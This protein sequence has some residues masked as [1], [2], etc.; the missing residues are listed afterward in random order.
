MSRSSADFPL[1]VD[2]GCVG[3]F[4][5]GR[6]VDFDNLPGVTR[7]DQMVRCRVADGS[8]VTLPLVEH[9]LLGKIATS[10]SAPISLL[11]YH[12]YA[13]THG[14]LSIHYSERRS[15]FRHR[16]MLH[17]FDAPLIPGVGYVTTYRT[18]CVAFEMMRL[19]PQRN[20]P[21]TTVP[22]S[23]A[24]Y[25]MLDFDR[26]G[27]PPPNITMDTSVPMDPPSTSI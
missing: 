25:I 5:L 22:P 17:L 27:A 10:Q 4:H 20:L 16:D 21:R 24:A 14:L 15:V 23:I 1:L 26:E 18:L 13:S 11:G 3:E 7:L 6:A 2:D 12:E 9:E 8:A 19:A